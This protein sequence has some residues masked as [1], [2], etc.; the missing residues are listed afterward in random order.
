MLVNN[1][2]RQVLHITHVM[3]IWGATMAEWLRVFDW[4]SLAS[5][6]CR[7]EPHMGRKLFHMRK[8]SSWLANG[9]WFY[10]DADF[11]LESL[12]D[13]RLKMALPPPVISWMSRNDWNTVETTLNPIRTKKRAFETWITLLNMLSWFDNTNWR[14]LFSLTSRV[15]VIISVISRRHLA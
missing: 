11:D 5:H 12:I 6:H 3:S 14:L 13:V 7:F 4:W 1:N 10:P 2:I 8:P 15:S 9:R